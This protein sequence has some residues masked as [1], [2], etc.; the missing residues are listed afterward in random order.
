[1]ADTRSSAAP[2]SRRA[3]LRAIV[4]VDERDRVQ[5]QQPG[6]G[7]SVFAAIHV[8]EEDGQLMVLGSTCFAKRYGDALGTAHFGSG[9]GGGRKLSDEE[10]EM[11]RR[12]T[13]ELLA[14]FEAEE[15]AA[16]ERA[17]RA[18][19]ERAAAERAAQARAAREAAA[20]EAQWKAAHRAEPADPFHAEAVGWRPTFPQHRLGPPG[21]SPPSPSPWP[22]QKTLSSVALFTAPEGQHWVRVQHRDGSQKL[23]PW[24]TFEGWEEALPASV[25]MADPVLG[26]VAVRDIVEAIRVLQRIGFSGPV[27]GTWQQVLPRRKAR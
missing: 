23:V 14:H 21:M 15:R 19:V 1:M 18:A 6:C 20:L 16:A 26:V 5:C 13:Q 10:R 4:S 2:S 3:R 11:L 22:W 12:N 8:V 9:G 17:Q 25:G 27:V 7:H 24:P